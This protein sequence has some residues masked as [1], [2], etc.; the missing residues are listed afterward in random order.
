MTLQLLWHTVAAAVVESG[1]RLVVSCVR[2]WLAILFVARLRSAS[3]KELNRN[4]VGCSFLMEVSVSALLAVSP[5]PH[6][7]LYASLGACIPEEPEA[8]L[9]GV[10]GSPQA[11]DSLSS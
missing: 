4:S 9:L 3:G 8:V 10:S 11:S 6:P 5:L 7:F 2:Q 1:E